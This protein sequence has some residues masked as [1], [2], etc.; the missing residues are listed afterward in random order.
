M[1]VEAYEIIVSQDGEQSDETAVAN[2]SKYLSFVDRTDTFGYTGDV[3]DVNIYGGEGGQDYGI[4]LC[5]AVMLDGWS[6][7]D[8]DEQFEQELERL[9]RVETFEQVHYEPLE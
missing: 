1:P 6:D 4:G 9:S 3:F 7:S 2:A 8:K 5:V